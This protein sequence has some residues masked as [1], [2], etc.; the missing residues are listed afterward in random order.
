[1]NAIDF[2]SGPESITTIIAAV[3]G[4]LILLANEGI[5]IKNTILMGA[6]GVGRWIFTLDFEDV[7][8]AS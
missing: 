4:G 8:L 3:F 7:I 6:A 1:M 5:L 2:T